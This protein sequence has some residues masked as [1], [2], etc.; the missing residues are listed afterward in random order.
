MHRFIIRMSQLILH[1]TCLHRYIF[2]FASIHSSFC[3][4]EIN[5]ITVCIDSLVVC[6]DSSFVFNILA[7]AHPPLYRSKKLPEFCF[8]QIPCYASIQTHLVSIHK[9]FPNSVFPFSPVCIDSSSRC[10]GSC[11]LKFPKNLFS[12]IQYIPIQIPY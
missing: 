9:L 6:I 5:S 12:S 1:F 11:S 10:I 8:L 2:S 4:L 3:F 7:S